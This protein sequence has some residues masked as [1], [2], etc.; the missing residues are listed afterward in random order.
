MFT[1]LKRASLLLSITLLVLFI[2]IIQLNSL[3]IV[4]NEKKISINNSIRPSWL[5]RKR[6]PKTRSIP[7]SISLKREAKHTRE[8]S[9]RL[10]RF[11]ICTLLNSGKGSMMEED[12]L[13]N[14]DSKKILK[15]EHKILCEQRKRKQVDFIDGERKSS[16]SYLKFFKRVR[17]GHD[18]GGENS[19]GL[20]TIDLLICGGIATAAGDLAL[21]PIDTIKTIQQASH[22]SISMLGACKKIVQDLGPF[23]FY[24]GVAPY[25]TMD[26]LAGSIKFATYEAAKKLVNPLLPRFMIP[27]SHFLCA[28]TAF[29]SCS[30]VLVPGEL[31]K[32]RLQAGVAQ[33]L[34]GGMKQIWLTEGFKGFF[35]G[36]KATLIRDVP[37]T[38]LE[39]G[40]YENFKSLIRWHKQKEDLTQ[41]DELFA[42]AVTGGIVGFL[43]NPLDLVKTRLM[44]G[45]P[46]E[47]K[48]VFD[49]ISQMYKNEGGMSVF[50]N[51]AQARVL[52]LLPFTVIHL[53]VYEASKRAITKLK[54]AK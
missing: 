23:G 22:V 15:K 46:T 31:L 4:S 41:R 44:T 48:G 39:L 43:T 5:P 36:Y 27:Y 33:T 9:R 18:N 16:S 35:T 2:N 37:Y 51:G 17:G 19:N 42:A 14:T 26:G 49:V 52:W 6:N 10:K 53:G 28:A 13:G 30:V 8:I 7:A 50:M 47:Y 20:S 54:S 1:L 3:K 40:L 24:A 12:R 29:M 32:Q 21:H 38:M 34:A 11:T 25:V 45:S